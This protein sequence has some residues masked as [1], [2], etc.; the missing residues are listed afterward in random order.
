MRG[1]QK[2]LQVDVFDWKTVQ[3]LYTNKMHI[4]PELMWA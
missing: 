2:V 3:Y 1:I 4:S